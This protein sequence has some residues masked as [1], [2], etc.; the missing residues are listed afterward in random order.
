M[1]NYSAPRVPEIKPKPF[2]SGRYLY[3][4]ISEG[5]AWMMAMVGNV[6][7]IRIPPPMSMFILVA[8]AERTRPSPN[9][10][11][12]HVAGKFPDFWLRL[13]TYGDGRLASKEWIEYMNE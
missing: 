2:E 12:L 3:G 9:T 13:K 8:F 7:P 5:I 1:E 11:Q 4:R 10:Y 6:K